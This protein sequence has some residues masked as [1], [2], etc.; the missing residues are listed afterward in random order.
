M[1]FTVC[2]LPNKSIKILNCKQTVNQDDIEKE[3]KEKKRSFNR[4]K[5]KEKE[6]LGSNVCFKVPSFFQ[7]RWF[8]HVLT[9]LSQIQLHAIVKMMNFY[10][11]DN[12]WKKDK[13]EV[14]KIWSLFCMSQFI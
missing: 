10:G 14:H 2:K 12:I 8:L 5:W 1:H 9:E 4:V 6:K 13:N 7:D 3:V 11:K